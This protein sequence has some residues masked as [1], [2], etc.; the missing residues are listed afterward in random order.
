MLN[1]PSYLAH[2]PGRGCRWCLSF[3]GW[4]SNA[5]ERSG[6]RGRGRGEKEL[7]A[8]KG[9]GNATPSP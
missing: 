2:S 5:V 4:V 3:V 6:G 8:Q 9:S 1:V 7:S